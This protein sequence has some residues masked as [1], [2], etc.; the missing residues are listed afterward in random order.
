MKSKLM[1]IG[2]A[3]MGRGN[4]GTVS[5]TITMTAIGTMTMMVTGTEDITTVI[6]CPWLTGRF[7]ARL[8]GV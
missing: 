1:N 7:G 4:T 8:A 5:F 3:I 6:D 2:A